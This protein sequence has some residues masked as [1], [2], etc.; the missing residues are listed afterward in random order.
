MDASMIIYILAVLFGVGAIVS[1]TRRGKV[2]GVGKN[3]MGIILLVL[4]GFLFALQMGYLVQISP[5]LAPLSIGGVITTQ[6]TGGTGGGYIVTT[7]PTITFGTGDAQQTGTTVGNTYYASVNGAPFGAVNTPTTAVPGQVIDFLIVNGTSYHNQAIRGLTVQPGSFP[8][9]VLMGRN[10]TMTES[11][12]TTTGLVI[13]NSLAG[14]GSTQNQTN[15][16]NGATYN[17]K[18][19]MSAGALQTTGDMVCVIELT[20]GINA[21]T[22]PSGASLA[23]NG[24]SLPLVSTSTPNWYTPVGVNSRIWMFNVPA[25]STSA[26]QTFQIQLNSLSTGSFSGASRMVKTCYSKENFIDPISGK[27]AY[28]V[29]DSQGTLKAMSQYKYT[30]WF[31]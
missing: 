15:L 23:L 14:A 1:F 25:I 4:G 30:A 24:Q 5:S 10:A 28:D 22:T 19:E 7:N 17:L 11:I 26:T 8:Q 20:A 9:Q 3:W 18:D 31:Q 21:T 29:A 13:T 2:M 16:G 27:L 12:Y 6:T